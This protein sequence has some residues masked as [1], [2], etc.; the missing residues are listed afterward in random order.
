MVVVATGAQA[1]EE[2]VVVASALKLQPSNSMLEPNS[3]PM[4]EAVV[5]VAM[6]LRVPESLD[7]PMRLSQQAGLEETIL[8]APAAMADF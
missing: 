1:E 6:G 3:R 5:V 4:V 8:W 7:N 2:A